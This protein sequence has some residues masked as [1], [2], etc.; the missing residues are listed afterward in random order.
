[1]KRLHVLAFALLAACGG[2]DA[3][4]APP[5][6]VPGQ[7]IDSGVSLDGGSTINAGYPDAWWTADLGQG[8]CGEGYKQRLYA[9]N[10]VA[11]CEAVGEDTGTPC[12][13]YAHLGWYRAGLHKCAKAVTP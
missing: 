12:G 1:M 2:I 3:L 6:A 10:D 5:D 9:P 7:A 4:D 11:W 13:E 8:Q